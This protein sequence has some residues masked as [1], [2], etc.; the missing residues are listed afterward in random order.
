MFSTL[1]TAFGQTIYHTRTL[2]LALHLH[3]IHYLYFLFLL[4]LLLASIHM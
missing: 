2:E 4:E 3:S 1:Q